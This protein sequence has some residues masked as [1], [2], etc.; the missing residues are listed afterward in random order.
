VKLTVLIVAALVWIGSGITVSSTT[1]TRHDAK[2]R[3]F[4][5][6]L[7]ETEQRPDVSDA[8]HADITVAGCKRHGAGFLCKGSLYPVSF[9]G[10][11]DSTCNFIVVV[12][13]HTTH[14]TVGDC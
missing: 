6:L 8:T 7:K 2:V 3:T 4:K 5:V 1:L 13:P 10:I 9:S 14:T 12:Y 11:P